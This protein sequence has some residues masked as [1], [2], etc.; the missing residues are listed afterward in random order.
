MK[1]RI[2]KVKNQ[3]RKFGSAQDYIALVESDGTRRLFT[4][5][6]WDDAAIRAKAN[7]EDFKRPG[8]WA[9]IFGK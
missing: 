5:H 4:Q 8:I 9:K 3:Q 1:A 6:V 2:Y 7:P